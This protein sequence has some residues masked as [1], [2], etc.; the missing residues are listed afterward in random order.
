MS[1]IFDFLKKTETERRR[2]T[3]I[4]EPALSD[5]LPESPLEPE[6]RLT[7]VAPEPISQ[8]VEVFGTDRFD[9]TQATPQMKNVLEPLTIVGEQFRLLRSR[10]G[11]MQK[12]RGIKTV[13]ITSTVPEEGKTFTASGLAGVFAQE[14]GKRVLLI[15]A[16]MRKPRSGAHFGISGAGD[17]NGLSEVLRGNVPMNQAILRSTNP[18]FCFLPSGPLPSNPSEL[19][20]SPQFE[21]ILRTAAENFDWV[22]VDSPPILSISDTNLLIPICDTVVLVMRANSTPAKLVNQA[23]ERIGREHI[24]GVVINRQKRATSSRY[25]Y[26][27]Y[28]RNSPKNN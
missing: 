7:P 23:V 11:L 22:I 6:L 21:R 12:Q 28:Y 14:P 2:N 15:D 24:C 4:P 27:Y 8:E 19:I 10:L 20:G 17:S 25:Y 1:E 16:D 3:G 5:P 18:E 9:L 26:Q 13:L